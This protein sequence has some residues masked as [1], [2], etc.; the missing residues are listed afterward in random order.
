MKAKPAAWFDPRWH[1]DSAR[2]GV[3]GSAA[4]DSPSIQ[5]WENEGGRYSTKHQTDPALA[6][7]PAPEVAPATLSPLVTLRRH[8]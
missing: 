6:V 3:L 5:N 8:G 2:P 7:P 4:D 1:V